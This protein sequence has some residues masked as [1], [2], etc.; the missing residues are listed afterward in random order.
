MRGAG[1]GK[2]VWGQKRSRS[3]PR[4]KHKT[5]SSATGTRTLV[6]CVKGKYDNHLHHGGLCCFIARLLLDNY[7][8]PGTTYLKVA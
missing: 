6:S 3:L 7:L 5:R 4:A 2:S 8:T 1:S